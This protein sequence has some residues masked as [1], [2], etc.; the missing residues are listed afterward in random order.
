MILLLMA[1]LGLCAGS[2]ALAMTIRMYDGRDWVNGRSECDLCHTSLNWYDLF[3]VVSWLST[4]GKCRYCKRKIGR[5][6]PA[7]ELGTAIA[8]V[9]SYNFWPY[10]FTKAG[11]AI[12]TLWLLMLTL[13]VS[14]LVFD[15]KWFILPDKLVYTLIALAGISKLVQVFYYQDFARLPGLGLSLVIGSGI[16]YLLHTISKGRYIGGGDVKYGLFFG[17]LL[18]SGFKSALVISV[19]SIIG[20]L[21]VLPSMIRHKTKMTSLI[22]FGPSLIIATL[23]LYIFGDRLITLITT[24]YLFP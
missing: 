14:L 11:I 3:P 24:A 10:G 1:I 17:M 6:F 23:I 9:V 5:L 19:G 12:F 21:L 7:V 16:F 8:F 4:G 2:F 13:M 22:P 20:T 18:G 15:L